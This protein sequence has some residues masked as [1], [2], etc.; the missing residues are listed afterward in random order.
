MSPTY[1]DIPQI[2]EKRAYIIKYKKEKG[3][4]VC[5]YNKCH[6]ALE[7]DHIDRSKK[8][9][10]MSKAYKLSWERLHKEMENCVILCA[11]CHR[12]KTIKEKDYMEV[13]WVEEESP[14]L[15]LL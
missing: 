15:N 7:Y 3:C 5:G 2:A 4:S 6:Q 14:Q 11:N 13:D 12:E 8:T 9:T 10:K 1:F